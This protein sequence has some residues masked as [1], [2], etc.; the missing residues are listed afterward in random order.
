MRRGR[1]AD[2]VCE[3][4]SKTVF[5][6]KLSYIHDASV[7]ATNNPVTPEPVPASNDMNS[8]KQKPGTR[9]DEAELVRKI[10]AGDEDAFK[11]LVQQYGSRLLA[12]S[13]R[14]VR[15]EADAHDCLQEAFLKCFTSIGQYEG[16]A[17]L[18]TWLHR[19]TVNVSLMRLRSQNR[20]REDPLDDMQPEF[21]SQG[22][23]IE[24][25]P[26]SEAREIEEL[27]QQ[28]QTTAAIRTAIDRLPNEYRAIV[29]ARDIEQM[30]T[31]EAAEVLDISK[32]LVKT[33]LHR[34]RAAL[35]KLLAPIVQSDAI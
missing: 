7:T 24:D 15:S 2:R 5:T 23:R 21:D 34:A 12:V 19:I 11:Q 16:R 32:P 4:F 22:M 25:A 6:G 28:G 29:I 3:L 35:K 30:S 20:N 14:I 10:L 26:L 1:F 33:R 17:S 13:R 8:S 9:F 31:A 27:Y 18:G